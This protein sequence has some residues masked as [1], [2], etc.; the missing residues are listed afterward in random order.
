MN[1]KYPSRSQIIAIHEEMKKVLKKEEGTGLWFYIDG[2]S[3]DVLAKEY[4]VSIASIRNLRLEVFG[5]LK[6]STPPS[7]EQEMAKR[8]ANL[9]HRVHMYEEVIANLAQRITRLEME[10][11]GPGNKVEGKAA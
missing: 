11:D 10:W 2:K 6:E 4:E 8:L 1:K 3:D 9:E 7:I 5:R